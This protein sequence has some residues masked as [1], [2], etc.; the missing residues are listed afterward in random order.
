MINKDYPVFYKL[1]IVQELF[2]HGQLF[3]DYYVV[4]KIG[5]I[6][7]DKNYLIQLSNWNFTDIPI[8]KTFLKAF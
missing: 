3:L 4:N 7:F 8:K 2:S 1:E 6:D 5:K